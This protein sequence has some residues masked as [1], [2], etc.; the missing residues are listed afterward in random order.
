M[1]TLRRGFSFHGPRKLGRTK[2]W[3]GVAVTVLENGGLIGRDPVNIVVRRGRR[4]MVDER[5]KQLWAAFPQF[6]VDYSPPW[7]LPTAE[8]FAYLA[9]R[10]ACLYPPKLCPVPDP[11]GRRPAAAR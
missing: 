11:L 5:F 9:E 6:T 8:D 3:T 4:I 2:C 10:Y 7:G 1:A